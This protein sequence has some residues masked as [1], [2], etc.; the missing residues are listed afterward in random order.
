MTTATDLVI[1]GVYDIPEE[2]YHADPVP[3]GSLS[4]SGAR[5]LLT[6]CPAVFMHEQLNPPESTA[7]LD[8]G[9]A[10][11]RM[12]LGVGPEFVIVD[13]K[14]W[15]TKAAQAKRKAARADG[16]VPLLTHQWQTVQDMASALRRH[17]HAGALLSPGHGD[18]EQTLIWRDA[19]TGVWRRARLDLLPRTTPGRMILV[20]YKTTKNA[21][22]QVLD[23]T[24]HEYGYHQQHAWYVDG[25]LA[26]GLASE[27]V[28]VFVFQ[29]KTPPYLITV[30]EIAASAVRI[31]RDRNRRALDL[32]RRCVETGEWPGYSSD[33]A[34]VS[35]P[36][37]AERREA[38]A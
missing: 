18:P 23:R 8:L 12:V 4:S 5:K 26:L 10:A 16:A 13:A 37:W 25:V 21:N 19:T 11:H 36:Y 7:E 22:P 29:E 33:I 15:T 9:K 2:Q 38:L 30:A 1:P 14:D 20:D 28:M 17:E 35:L 6:R 3:C 24:I 27:V 31:G 32:Y 34:Y